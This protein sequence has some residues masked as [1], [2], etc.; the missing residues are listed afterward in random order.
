MDLAIDTKQ[1]GPC[2][3]PSESYKRKVIESDWE[4]VLK[5][6]H[7]QGWSY[8]FTKYQDQG[9]GEVCLV[10]ASRGDRRE[11]GVGETYHEAVAALVRAIYQVSDTLH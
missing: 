5:L 3:E 2:H 6:L 4:D 9:G 11:R 7:L 1:I 10:D 8:G